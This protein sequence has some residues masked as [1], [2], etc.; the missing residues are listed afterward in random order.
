VFYKINVQAFSNWKQE[1]QSTTRKQECKNVNT[2]K[3]LHCITKLANETVSELA[4]RQFYN[5][6]QVH[7]LTFDRKALNIVISS[8]S[9]AA[10]G[11]P[12]SVRM[13]SGPPAVRSANATKL[14]IA[15]EKLIDESCPATTHRR[16][17]SALSGV[18]PALWRSRW[19]GCTGPALGGHLQQHAHAH[20]QCA[21]VTARDLIAWLKTIELSVR[22]VG[23][24]AWFWSP[25]LIYTVF[26]ES[27]IFVSLC[28]HRAERIE[29]LPIYL[30]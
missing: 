4:K 3:S 11:Q 2:E 22:S 8:Y 20:S 6:E 18:V 9:S 12:C 26:H 16:L 29:H 23:K 25:T 30:T 10:E 28:V 1:K 17:Q 21:I 27:P 15:R 13:V 24:T 19:A 14:S 7:G 5:G